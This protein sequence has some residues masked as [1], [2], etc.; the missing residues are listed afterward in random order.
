MPLREYVVTRVRQEKLVWVAA[1]VLGGARAL[2][3]RQM[4]THT[5]A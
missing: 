5:S 1:A 4:G 3:A 2:T